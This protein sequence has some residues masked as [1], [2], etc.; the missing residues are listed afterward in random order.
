MFYNQLKVKRKI[1]EF[2]KLFYTDNIM[3]FGN[4]FFNKKVF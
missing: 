3:Q 4:N 2:I 1:I